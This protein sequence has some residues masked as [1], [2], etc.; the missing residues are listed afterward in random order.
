MNKTQWDAMQ[1]FITE[2]YRMHVQFAKQKFL[3]YI[4]NNTQYGQNFQEY[5]YDIQKNI[6]MILNDIRIYDQMFI[7]LLNILYDD[8]IPE[9]ILQLLFQKKKNHILM[10]TFLITSNQSLSFNMYQWLIYL[11]PK[12]YKYIIIDIDH[13]HKKELKELYEFLT[14]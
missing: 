3:N 10:K 14:V 2:N 4:Q 13:P 12:Y 11:N 6:I 1:N 5:N 9:D 7:E 8:F